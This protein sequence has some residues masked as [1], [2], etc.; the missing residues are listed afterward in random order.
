MEPFV[1]LTLWPKGVQPKPCAQA[2][3]FNLVGVFRAARLKCNPENDLLLEF[4]DFCGLFRAE[5]VFATLD[6]SNVSRGMDII[7]LTEESAEVLQKL[8]AISIDAPPAVRTKIRKQSAEQKESSE[9]HSAKPALSK[10]A[11]DL[12]SQAAQKVSKK[13]LKASAQAKKFEADLNVNAEDFRKTLLG[14]KKIGKFVCRLLEKEQFAF[15]A[16]SVFDSSGWCKI[17]GCQDVC[18]KSLWLRAP[19]YFECKYFKCTATQFGERVFSDL[20]NILDEVT[21]E[22]PGH[23]KLQTLIRDVVKSGVAESATL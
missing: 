21:A 23:S 15:G 17:T 5:N 18:A 8:A 4:T 1:I 14:K 16:K 13:A 22:N 12:V 7:S 10:A 20:K 3:P 6:C 2:V 19:R 11:A 9:K